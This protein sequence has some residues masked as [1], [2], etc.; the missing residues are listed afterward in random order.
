ILAIVSRHSLR[1]HLFSFLEAGCLA[2]IQ[3]YKAAM[4][5]YWPKQ[6][7]EASMEQSL[8]QLATKDDFP[9]VVR[10]IMMKI[11]CQAD[12]MKYA[13]SGTLM[14]IASMEEAAHNMYRAQPVSFCSGQACV[15]DA[16]RQCLLVQ[17]LDELSKRTKPREFEKRAQ[18]NCKK[19]DAMA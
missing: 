1:N 11:L 18:E 16:Y 6:T 3:D 2:E 7:Q 8:T 15:L 13:T 12:C 19:I 14:L 17:A 9:Y 5:S 10:A 4:R